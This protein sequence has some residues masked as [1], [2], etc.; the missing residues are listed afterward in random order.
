[1]SKYFKESELRCNCGCGFRAQPDAIEK[2]DQLREAF[3]KPLN[4]TSSARCVEHNKAIDGAPMSKHCEGIAFDFAISNDEE[5]RNLVALMLQFGWS[6]IGVGK[7]FVHGDLRTGKNV[8][9]GY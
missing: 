2:A 4:V 6:G 9:W 1:M 7:G 3:G 8:M 5:R